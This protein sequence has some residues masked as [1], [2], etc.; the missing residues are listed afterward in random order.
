MKKVYFLLLI[1]LCFSYSFY[2][3]A[4][5]TIPDPKFEQAL[6]DLGIDTDG[7]VNGE[8]A[9]ADISGIEKLDVHWKEITDLT[10]IGGFS[11]LEVLR[12]SSNKLTSLDLSQNV[13]LRELNCNNNKLTSIDVSKCKKLEQ[14][15]CEYNE[16]QYLD[17]TENSELEVLVCGIGNKI[18]YYGKLDLRGNL[19]LKHLKCDGILLKELDVSQNDSLEYLGCSR[20]YIEKLDLELNTLLKT[21]DC[22]S[23]QID[24]LEL[25]EN[26]LLISLDCAGNKLTA[27]DL[28]NNNGI[29][30]LNC[31]GNQITSLD[32]SQARSLVN[33]ACSNN[34]LTSL[35]VKNGNN[36]IIYA[37][38]AEANDLLFCIQVDDAARANAGETPY[39]NWRKDDRATYS[40]D[41]AQP[42]TISVNDVFEQL[43]VD[44]NI[45]SDGELNGEVSTSDIYGLLELEVPSG[46]G[47]SNLDGIENLISL[48][49]L[50]VSDIGLTSLDL[51][52]NPTLKQLDCSNN[53][54]TSLDLSNNP[55]LEQ[56]D[57]SNNQL[58]SLDLSNN[59]FL[60]QLDCSN[61]QLTSLDLN[62]NLGL[63]QLDCSNNL[64]TNLD[65]SNNQ[66]LTYIDVSNNP[67]T[68][69]ALI[70]PATYSPSNEAFDPLSDK[71]SSPANVLANTTLIYLNISNT[72][73]TSI[74]ISDFES[75][76][77]LDVSGS[78]LDSLDVS[79]NISLR[80]LNTTNTT[81]S[82][83][84]V[85]QDQLGN[86]PTG[87]EKEATAS[88]AVDCQSASSIEDELLAASIRMY[89]NPVN[90]ILTIES[91][92]RL[93]KIEIYSIVGSKV[94]E[95]YMDFSSI[96]TGHL[97]KGIYILKIHSEK[98]ISTK[99]FTKE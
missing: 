41:C 51:S 14:L 75:L 24:R 30:V 84:Q 46:Y 97:S 79:A 6:I 82:C 27:L 52:N 35:N 12:C 1:L 87:W 42:I 47:I 9:T 54:L 49:N 20:N 5:T 62:N 78:K 44:L 81:L 65:L 88:Y 53:Q 69:G 36:S 2:S 19:R 28:S 21:I 13:S 91:D 74:D 4:Q 38:T 3:Y 56:L 31:A 58:T 83:I 85:N 50:I 86:I 59:P 45:D 64:L 61:N 34:L 17:V 40:E 23:N 90:D 72:D 48:E 29:G 66:Y 92:F 37:F 39:H 25:Y 15:A 11:N 71:N 26:K 22:S 63:H 98:G 7:T 10:G 77:T 99:K 16:L 73:M 80:Y 32:L 89:P 18:G 67:I 57:C 33:I 93:T 43:L 8:V 70:L 55:F 76:V 96:Q 95:I 60:E 94:K 68:P